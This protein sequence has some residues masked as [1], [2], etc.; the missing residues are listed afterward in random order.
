MNQAQIMLN[1]AK[2]KEC[3]SNFLYN[4][5]NEEF[6]DQDWENE[7][8]IYN[9]DDGSKIKDCCGELSIA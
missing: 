4:T 8:T 2:S 9:F 5:M 7:T 1:N 6:R 3:P